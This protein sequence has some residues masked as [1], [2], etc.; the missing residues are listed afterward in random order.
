M[1]IR[2]L[3]NWPLWAQITATCAIVSIAIALATGAFVR[4]METDY[5]L[6]NLHEQSERAFNTIASTS[7]DAVITEDAA[8]LETLVAQVLN[9]EPSIHSLQI[10]NE[11]G[12]QLVS[13]R[14]GKKLDQ[15]YLLRFS[16]ELAF[17]GETF[18]HMTMEWDVSNK[19]LK[20]EQHVWDMYFFTIQM[21]ALL[22][23]AI[24]LAVHWL[25]TRPLRLIGQRI[26]GHVQG[27]LTN[28]TTPHASREFLH[29]SRTLDKMEALTISREALAQEV[30]ERR[31][32][33]T[34]LV[35]ARDEALRAS[36][37]KN[38][39]LANMSHEIRTPMN[40][41][42]GMTSLLS[43]TELSAPQRDY[44]QAIEASGDALLTVIDDI[45]DFSKIEAGKLRLE[46]VDFNVIQLVEDV[47]HLL[48]GRA[49]SKGLELLCDIFADVPFGVRGDP[50]RLRQ[51]LTNLIGN[52]IKFTEQGEVVVRT[53]LINSNGD[54]IELRFEI[55]DTG[56][57]IAPK[58]RE[59]LFESFSQADSSTTRK[60]GGTGLGLA[61]SRQLCQMMG[62]NIGVESEPGRGSTF[63]FTVWLQRR[64][65]KKGAVAVQPAD[66]HGVRALIVDDNST[67]RTILL[68][69]TQAWGMTNDSAEGGPQTL[70]LLRSAATRGTPYDIAI[71]DMMMPGMDGLE[72]ART[73]KSDPAISAVRLVMLTSMGQRGDGTE[74]KRAGIVGYLTKPVRQSRLHECLARVMGIANQ[75]TAERLVTRHDLAEYRIRKGAQVLVAEDDPI[76]QRVAFRFLEDLGVQATVVSD[77]VEA[78]DAAS[79]TSYDLI[80]MDCQ[81]PELDG[82]AATARI[83]EQEGPMR[84]TPIIALTANAMQ[85]DRE[86]C[87][88]AAMDDYLTKPLRSTELAQKLIKWLGEDADAA[89]DH[90]AAGGTPATALDHAPPIDLEHVRAAYGD[91]QEQLHDTL[92]LF[93]DLTRSRLVELG[94]ALSKRDHETVNRLAHTI[95]GSSLSIGAN[96]LADLA[97][98]L[99]QAATRNDDAL[100]PSIYRAMMENFARLEQFVTGYVASRKRALGAY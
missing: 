79:R 19:Y 75:G 61:I 93:V 83:R 47:M 88:S 58:T 95:K 91:S 54:Q 49:Q 67:N 41:V 98:E 5:L 92:T 57:G 8:L 24:I 39:F 96:K 45:L 4:K 73:I 35:L 50:G 22:C 68:R 28:G 63:W 77:G 71:L 74:A 31:H 89:A 94:S 78:V 90:N 60:H 76:S 15:Q 44:V 99:G 34:E 64:A 40:G 6:E 3:Q 10:T 81:M 12:I 80:L 20:I 46:M 97:R 16:D 14:S 7:I 100:L 72:L 1:R 84:R 38:S 59:R 55:R 11:D 87:L 48:A 25:V 52:A 23:A 69:Q 53:T 33:Q 86:R 17:E 30:K 29:L 9:V 65:A 66:L 56:I 62:G 43:A 36:Q 70:D 18:G 21:L 82:F 27:S 2:I 85:G 13:R 26:L 32:A 51:V 42:L 37:A